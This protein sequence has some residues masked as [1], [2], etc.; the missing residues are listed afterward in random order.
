MK[1]QADKMACK[2]NGKLKKQQVREM[3]SWR[4]GKLEKWRVE[5]RQVV[6]MAI[7]KNVK[8]MT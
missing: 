6:K 8:L 2:G 3:A 7:G 5:K 1:W 4:N